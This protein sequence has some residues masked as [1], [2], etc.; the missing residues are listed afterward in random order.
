M[1]ALSAH[2]AWVAQRLTAVYLAVYLIIGLGCL[3]VYGVPADA[4]AWRRLFSGPWMNLFTL[5]LFL[6][7]I[8]HA[9]IGIRDVILDYVHPV[10]IRFALLVFFGAGLLLCALWAGRILFNAMAA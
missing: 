4:A 8:W 6:A 3:A 9:W 5:G 1:S 2:K 10:W 7:L